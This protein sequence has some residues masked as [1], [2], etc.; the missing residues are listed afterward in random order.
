MPTNKLKKCAEVLVIDSE[1]VIRLEADMEYT[2]KDVHDIK[3]DIREIKKSNKNV[4]VA[5]VELA[6]IARTNQRLFPR[7][8]AI[9]KEVRKNNMKLATWGGGLTVLIFLLGFFG[10]DIKTVGIEK[11][12]RHSTLQDIPV[13]PH[14]TKSSKSPN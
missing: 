14:V 6:E 8:E 1:R 2:Q 4:E 9:E 11:V 12:R 7:L 5:I 3:S 10:S 13:V